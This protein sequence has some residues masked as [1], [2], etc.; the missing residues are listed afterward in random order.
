M[1][2]VYAVLGTGNIAQ[3]I[4]VDFKARGGE[5]RLFAPEKV[6]Y[7]F[8][9]IAE[10]KTIQC[11]GALEAREK[12]DVVTCDIDEAVKGADYIFMCVTG[13]HHEEYA[14][15]LVGH[16]TKE[17]MLIIFNGCM[18][19]LIYKQVWGDDPECP[20]FVES[21]IPPFST[22]REGPGQVRMYERHL[23]PVSFF[24]ADASDRCFKALCEDVYEFP[25][26]FE[27]ALECGLSLV[28]PTIHPG[29][30][31]VNLSNIEKPDF[32][33]YLYEHGFQPS[34]LKLDKALNE[35]RL[36]IGEAFGY[37]IHALEDFAGVEKIESWESLYAMGHGCHAL[38]SIAGPNDINYRYMTEDTPVALVC[39][40]SLADQLGIDTPVMESVITIMGVA[41]E[42]DWFSEGR[43]A[44][45]LGLAGRSIDEIKRYAKTGSFK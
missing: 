26:V 2:K 15:L 12:I 11:F 18:A 43:S 22:R 31:L 8:G 30:C 9:S 36:A 19:S 28:N 37:K 23:A 32:K 17:Q 27:D 20:V 24:P 29:P 41:H 39:W 14:K 38:T 10:N 44:E 5:V 35:E 7:R 42:R 25:A 1:G 3:T 40:A 16:T 21:T 13:E 4:A 33:F 34:G 6:F 45:R